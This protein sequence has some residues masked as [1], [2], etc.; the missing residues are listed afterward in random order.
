MEL[1]KT[2]L[3]LV[4]PV[5]KQ[6]QTKVN[7]D[8]F[9][10]IK[11]KK[12]EV[13]FSGVLTKTGNSGEITQLNGQSHSPIIAESPNFRKKIG[14]AM[15]EETVERF[16]KI[17]RELFEDPNWKGMRLKYQKLFLLILEHVSYRTRI[18]KHNGNSIT[19]F[20]G[21]LCIS[22]RR[23]AELFNEDVKWKDERIDAPLVQRA[24]SVFTK[25]GFS[26]QETIHGIM[27]L[28]ITQ[29]EL[30]EHFKKQTDTPSDTQP[31]HNRYTNEE[32]K[33]RK[34]VKE[35]NDRADA[36]DRSFLLNNQKEENQE[37]IPSVFDAPE[38]PTRKN[39]QLTSEQQKQYEDI[40]QYLCKT[41]MAE[42][43][44]VKNS[45]GRQI[46]GVTPQDVVTW[47]KTRPFKEIVEAIKSTKDANVQTNYPGYITTLFK[48]N[49]MAKKDNIQINDE[50]LQELMK[51]NKCVHLEN[52]KQY[53]TDNLKHTDYQ[54]N[55][56]PQMFKE[57]I[58]RSCE[59]AFSYS[60]KESEY[61]TN[62]DY[63][64]Y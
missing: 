34:E 22:F 11:N 40:W 30:Y 41:K 42:G 10:D 33:E 8:N 15:S 55:T 2:T 45:K 31:I 47:L 46:K 20:P 1:N 60:N 24:V 17:P 59:M 6:L 48:K 14:S 13:G 63:D 50:F 4:T 28:S 53:V 37:S 57:M 43:S 3:R 27:R 7:F 5:N 19:V 38:P 54:K 25:F 62:E 56:D 16:I 64:D 36:P 12:P 61:E 51:T 58:L 23:L 44:T 49:V 21:Q 52:H 32:R 29:R 26:I 18:Y 9:N 35:T 39:Q